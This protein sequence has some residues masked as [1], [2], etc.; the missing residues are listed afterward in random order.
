M[1]TYH[2]WPEKIPGT[3]REEPILEH[4]SP[5]TKR[6]RAAILI[7]PGGGYSHRAPHEGVGYAEFLNDLG[8]EAFV[9]AYRVT[10]GAPADDTPL[11]PAPLLDAR[12]AVRYLRHNA[13]ALGIDTDKIAVMGSSAGGHL[14]AFVST[15]RAPIEGE[16]VDAI[17]EIDCIPN[18]QILCYPVISSDEE[19]S[20]CRSYKCLLGRLYE[21]RDTY[22]PDLIADERTPK[23]FLWHTAADQAVNVIN[24]YRYA[25]ALRKLN[26]PCEMHIFPYGTHGRGVA[27]DDPH[28]HQWVGLLKNWFILNEYL[29][30]EE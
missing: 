21:E 15:Y 30:A 6:S 13:D 7:L 3:Y 5:K 8:I 10:G 26:I 18:A 28:L 24:S 9:L 1:N 27:A 16:G 25:T 11:F 17:D 29:P 14:A 22:S 23:A 4:Y 19:V 2:L 12:R 20:H